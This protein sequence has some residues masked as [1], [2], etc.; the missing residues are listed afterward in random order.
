MIAGKLKVQ[1]V[2]TETPRPAART[3]VGDRVPRPL[4]TTSACTYVQPT[5]NGVTHDSSSP[6]TSSQISV[7]THA[8]TP[9]PCL[10]CD[11]SHKLRPTRIDRSTCCATCKL[12]MTD[13]HGML[14]CLCLAQAVTPEIAK[15]AYLACQQG[16][17]GERHNKASHLVRTC[18]LDG[19]AGG[20]HRSA[21]NC[22]AL[23][24]QA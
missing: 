18:A 6:K 10:C 5:A 7:K 22:S 14:R 11:A 3:R 20:S 4:S 12:S 23:K 21:M 24:E 9:S 1:K 2:T 13:L 17:C 8:R 19:P 15:T 16:V